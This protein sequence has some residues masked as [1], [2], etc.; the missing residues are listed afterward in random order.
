MGQPSSPFH[1][2]STAGSESSLL[3]KFS[4][5]R[6]SN[7]PWEQND[8]LS[9]E[10]TT[11]TPG[12]FTRHS[13]LEDIKVVTWWSGVCLVVSQQ[14]GSGIFSTPALVNN[15]AGSVGMSLIVWIIAGCIAWSGACTFRQFLRSNSSVVC[16]TG[17]R[18]TCQWGF[19]CV[20]ALCVWAPSCFLVLLDDNYVNET[21]FSSNACHNF[22]RVY[23]QGSLLVLETQPIY[24]FL[25]R[26]TRGVGLCLDCDC[27]KCNRFR[28]GN[29][30][31]QFVRNH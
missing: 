10:V 8:L 25:G 14:I 5:W 22:W 17:I 6:L 4:L 23:Q 19:V 2:P 24:P 26:Q 11:E 18:N 7:A 1:D 12:I 21:C 28:M 27:A 13:R 30:G 3:R 31:E 16:R 15:A 29:Q 9:P 20:L